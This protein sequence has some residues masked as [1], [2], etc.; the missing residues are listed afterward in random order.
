[1]PVPTNPHLSKTHLVLLQKA[2]S[3]ASDEVTLKRLAERHG[4]FLLGSDRDS[5]RD[6]YRAARRRLGIG[7]AQ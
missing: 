1:M 7:G 2:L 6:A 5:G 4:A 3:Q